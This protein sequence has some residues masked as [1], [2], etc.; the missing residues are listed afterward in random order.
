MLEVAIRALYENCYAPRPDVVDADR[1]SRP[2]VRIDGALPDAGDL[3]TVEKNHVHIE[4]VGDLSLVCVHRERGGRRGGVDL[5]RADKPPGTVH[6]DHLGGLE[7]NVEGGGE[8]EV[9]LHGW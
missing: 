9:H 3:G 8:L 6:G 7:A 4:P 1:V 5:E 2:L